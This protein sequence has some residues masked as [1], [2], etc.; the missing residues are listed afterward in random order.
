MDMKAELGEAYVDEE[1]HDADGGALWNAGT[2][3]AD[4]E[5]HDPWSSQHARDAVVLLL[6]V[7]MVVA[8]EGR[9]QGSP[10]LSR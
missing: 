8:H 1:E 10:V 3:S 7:P 6:D 4:E 5:E 2:F 9:V